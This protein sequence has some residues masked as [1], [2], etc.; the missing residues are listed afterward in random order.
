M[1]F[2]GTPRYLTSIYA[3][4]TLIWMKIKYQTTDERIDSVIQKYFLSWGRL[5]KSMIHTWLHEVSAFQNPYADLQLVHFYRYVG[6]KMFPGNK[7]KKL[8]KLNT[9]WHL[10]VVAYAWWYADM[11]WWHMLPCRFNISVHNC[12]LLDLP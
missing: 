9:R 11:L 7:K 4:L 5:L 12:L 1:L 6:A 10:Y 3:I 8:R 2:I